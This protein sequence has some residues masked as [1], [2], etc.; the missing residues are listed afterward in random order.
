MKR[1]LYIVLVSLVVGAAAVTAVNLVVNK[2]KKECRSSNDY[3]DSCEDGESSDNNYL[4]EVIINQ[5]EP[6]YEDIKSSAIGN[7]YSRHL[8]AAITMSESIKKIHEN[9]KISESINDEID[10]VSA[11]LD[12]MLSE[13]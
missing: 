4:T 9:I 8:D 7:M 6:M 2:K 11:E 13:D 3:R 12:K 1:E 10:A 5:D